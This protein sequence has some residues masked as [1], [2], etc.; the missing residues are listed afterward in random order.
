M[1][2]EIARMLGMTVEEMLNKMSSS[3]LTE[4][5]AYLRMRGKTIDEAFNI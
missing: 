4:W 1:Y 5:I 3:E 2:F